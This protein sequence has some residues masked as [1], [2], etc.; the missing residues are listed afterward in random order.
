MKTLL[1]REMIADRVRALGAELTADYRGRRPVCIALMN[2]A[3]PFAA[4]L[5][6]AMDVPLELDTLS[7]SSYAGQQSTGEI[8]FRSTLKLPVAGRDV[9]LID[10]ILDSGVTLR[11][12]SD[13]LLREA[14]AAQ[15]RTCVLLD[16]KIPRK[17]EALAHA[18]YTG[19]EIED[20]FVVGYGLDN[21]EAFRN[22]PDIS[23]CD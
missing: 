1:S 19:F 20:L 21:D 4:D 12:L 5:I 6:R 11:R 2:G 10:D 7:V 3:L 13:Y 18:D 8:K 17:P 9:L 15:V 23:V 14:N 22:L 16:K